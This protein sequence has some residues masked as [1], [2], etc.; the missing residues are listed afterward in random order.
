MQGQFQFLHQGVSEIRLFMEWFGKFS[1]TIIGF[2][3]GGWLG[4]IIGLVIG[5]LVDEE[6]TY[7]AM[8]KKRRAARSADPLESKHLA[9]FVCVFSML[10]KL[11]K[12]DGAIS[13]LEIA[14]VDRFIKDELGLDPGRRKLAMNIFRS[15]KIS[16]TSFEQHATDFYK[17]FKDDRQVLE[18]LIDILLRLSSADGSTGPEEERM[19]RKAA[20][21][22]QIDDPTIE[23]LRSMHKPAPGRNYSILG[24]SKSSTVAE[25][26]RSYRKLV[27]ENHPDRV[28][29][30][31]QPE[32]F[33]RIA[34]D[35]FRAIQ[36]AYEAIREERG[37]S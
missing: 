24:C 11:A 8:P 25:I 32:E 28:R 26:K 17:A 13:A 3:I 21:T 36:E 7:G 4:A 16:P 15:A 23:R 35:K 9:F 22:F 12:V 37:F 1:C 34:N 29:A 31:G 6:E 10:A 30:Q 27:M 18:N 14:V 2:Y 19:I 20:R 5:H 33:I